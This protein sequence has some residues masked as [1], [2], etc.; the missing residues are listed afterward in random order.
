MTQAELRK[1]RWAAERQH[2]HEDMHVQRDAPG[3]APELYTIDS[4]PLG[5][6]PES[7]RRTAAAALRI[8]ASAR[9]SAARREHWRLWHAV[10]CLQSVARGWASRRALAG[11]R[12][13]LGTPI[14]HPMTRL[15][16]PAARY[17]DSNVD[18][19][20]SVGGG[21]HTSGRSKAAKSSGGRSRSPRVGSPRAGPLLSLS[22]VADRLADTRH[23]VKSPPISDEH[24]RA[25][26]EN[27]R[28]RQVEAIL[29]N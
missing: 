15:I 1:Q 28:R 10:L 11:R 8:Q 13:R 26:L 16:V 2:L 20:K 17:F 24:L 4:N 3:R 19:G 7:Q 9:R 21:K 29:H 14:A 22:N 18:R 5:L 25:E 23:R 12:T 6:D 27:A